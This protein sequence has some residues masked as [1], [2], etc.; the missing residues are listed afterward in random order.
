[1]SFPKGIRYRVICAYSC[2]FTFFCMTV[3]RSE[4]PLYIEN[5]FHKKYLDAVLLSLIPT[6]LHKLN[7][8]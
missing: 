8:S 2:N 6:P 4:S 7:N 1:M 5:C 3:I